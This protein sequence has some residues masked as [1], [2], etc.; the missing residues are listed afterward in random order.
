MNRDNK[1]IEN[2]C[3]DLRVIWQRVPALRFGQFMTI[4]FESIE[5][6]GADPFYTE[7]AQFIDIAR[8]KIEALKRF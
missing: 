1:A 4:I 8:E 5:S 2:F 6:G 7:D 3:T